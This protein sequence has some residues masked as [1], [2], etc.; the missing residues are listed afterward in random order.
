MCDGKVLLVLDFQAVVQRDI[1]LVSGQQDGSSV[2]PAP[3][4]TLTLTP[5]RSTS[6][7]SSPGVSLSIGAPDFSEPNGF[8]WPPLPGCRSRIGTIAALLADQP[9][10]INCR[11][12]LLGPLSDL[13]ASHPG[14]SLL[15]S[16]QEPARIF[17]GFLRIS[18][19][20]SGQS[21]KVSPRLRLIWQILV[22][23]LPHATFNAAK[24]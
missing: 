19:S 7:F 17:Q 2:I 10:R 1:I 8:A 20:T 4:G 11:V 22:N 21:Q 18:T 9:S 3:I 24:N 15:Q 5:N 14:C 16:G 12:T 13:L 23:Q 6:I